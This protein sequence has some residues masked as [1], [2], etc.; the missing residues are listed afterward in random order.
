MTF[1]QSIDHG[2]TQSPESFSLPT[3]A[4]AGSSG[5][6][7]VIVLPAMGEELVPLFQLTMLEINISPASNHYY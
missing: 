4:K 2:G 6:D 7:N 5:A 1:I 3:V